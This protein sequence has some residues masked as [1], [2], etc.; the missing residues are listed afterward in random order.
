MA[1][2]TQTRRESPLIIIIVGPLLTGFI[3]LIGFLLCV[4]FNKANINVLDMFMYGSLGFVIG[5][6]MCLMCSKAN[7]EE[8]N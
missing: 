4:I 3:L 1:I 7:N 6:L 2:K 5:V 8:S